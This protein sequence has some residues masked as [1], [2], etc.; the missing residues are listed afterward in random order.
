MY[1]RENMNLDSLLSI[2]KLWHSLL[3][4]HELLNKKEI[5]SD[6]DIPI[7]EVTNAIN[8]AASQ[9]KYHLDKLAKSSDHDVIYQLKNLLISPLLKENIPTENDENGS[10]INNTPLTNSKPINKILLYLFLA[11]TSLIDTTKKL[12]LSEK[13]VARLIELIYN[14]ALHLYD[15]ETVHIINLFNFFDYDLKFENFGLSESK[16]AQS[17]KRSFLNRVFF[18]KRKE[19]RLALIYLLFFKPNEELRTLFLS[20]LKT[21][22][23]TSPP[24]DANKT[25]QS[26]LEVEKIINHLSISLNNQSFLKQETILTILREACY[27]FL[28][29][30]KENL[31]KS[32]Q[33]VRNTNVSS[34]I[35][36]PENHIIPHLNVYFKN[37]RP[38]Y[39]SSFLIKLDLSSLK[40]QI[41]EEIEAIIQEFKENHLKTLEA[42]NCPSKATT[43]T[44]EIE[45]TTKKLRSRLLELSILSIIEDAFYI[46]NLSLSELVNASPSLSLEAKKDIFEYSIQYKLKHK[47]NYQISEIS[48][49]LSK[50]KSDLVYKVLVQILS[51]YHEKKKLQKEFDTSLDNKNFSKVI[52]FLKKGMEDFFPVFFNKKEGF[53]KVK[54]TDLVIDEKLI[55]KNLGKF[56]LDILNPKKTVS[57]EKIVDYVVLIKYDEFHK[58]ER[59]LFLLYQ[60]VHRLKERMNMLLPDMRKVLSYRLEAIKTASFK[61]LNPWI[62]F[63]VFDDLPKGILFDDSLFFD[64]KLL[65]DIGFLLQAANII[66]SEIGGIAGDSRYFWR[67]D[68][69]S[70]YASILSSYKEKVNSLFVTY[71][72]DDTLLE[73]LFDLVVRNLVE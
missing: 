33:I 67:R 64:T 24:K 4:P 56:F 46:N 58:C 22:A 10:P 53:F 44:T 6:E 23:V 8:N 36:D 37:T 73:S 47:M 14:L 27:L 2:L 57:I 25:L 34:W 7:E 50:E 69:Y 18:S 45:E 49:L 42:E 12:Y 70:Q 15:I 63:C 40:K 32:P 55:A 39:Y 48:R 66:H 21:I 16:I 60:T 72:K 61:H 29:Q 41:P 65:I 17:I 51:L 31:L 43:P 71:Q 13:E 35:A 5:P 28:E 62:Y 30:V 52:S 38:E 20:K 3:N 26:Y 9:L 54:F 68:L 59:K 11:G 19:N 1:R